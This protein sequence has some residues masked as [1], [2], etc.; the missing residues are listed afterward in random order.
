MGILINNIKEKL[1][2]LSRLIRL[3]H[4]IKNL[5]IFM[6]LFFAGKIN[7]LDL[8]LNAVISFIAFCAIASAIYILND[9]RDLS[10]DLQHPRKKFR[11]IA[12]GAISIKNA[13]LIMA[14]LLILGVSLL[15]LL[16][17]EALF[18][19]IAYILL[20]IA[21]SFYLKKIAIVDVTVIAIGFVLRVFLGSVVTGTILSE[22]LIIMTFLIAMFIAFAKRRDDVLLFLDSGKKM[23]KVVDGYNLKFIDIVMSIISSVII[24]VYILYSVSN[25]VQQR[26]QNEYIY[27]TTLFVILGLMRY[28][29]L[30]FIKENTGSPIMII[31]YDRFIKTT[32]FLW[33]LSFVFIIYL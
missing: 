4:Y 27:F 21:Y 22:W 8:L 9:I 16:F 24:V 25:E 26:F 28:L 20:N 3:S 7:N 13:I 23:R 2:N 14:I 33:V 10:S 6:P 17:I 5:F 18:I 1:I 19:L 15:A 32:I 29:Q 31:L 30:T 11:P 12:S